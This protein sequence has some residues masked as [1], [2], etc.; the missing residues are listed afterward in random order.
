MRLPD[1]VGQEVGAQRLQRLE[2]EDG[3][4]LGDAVA[5]LVVVRGGRSQACEEKG[6]GATNFMSGHF[7]C[8]WLPRFLAFTVG[9]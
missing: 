3:A 7:Q 2:A 4:V 8:R 9:S 5:D 6:Y 1:P